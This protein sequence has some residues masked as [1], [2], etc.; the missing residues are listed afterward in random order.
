MFPDKAKV[1]SRVFLDF[2]L[3]GYLRWGAFISLILALF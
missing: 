1:L 3:T 2:W